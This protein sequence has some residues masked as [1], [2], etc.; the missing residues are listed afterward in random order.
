LWAIAYNFGETMQQDTAASIGLLE[1]SEKLSELESMT[2]YLNDMINQ[3][4]TV[5]ERYYSPS[6]YQSASAAY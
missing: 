4:L 1:A 2:R 6:S 3:Y 5:P